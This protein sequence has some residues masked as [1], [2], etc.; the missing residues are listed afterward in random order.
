MMS[1]LKTLRPFTSLVPFILL[2]AASLPLTGCNTVRGV[3]DDLK[4]AANATEK[5]ITKDEAE[6]KK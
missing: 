6:E 4:G 3:G 2:A 5:V 1:T